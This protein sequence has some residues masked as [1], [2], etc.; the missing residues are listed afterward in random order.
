MNEEK[1][2]VVTSMLIAVGSASNKYLELILLLNAVTYQY[3]INVY[4]YH[5]NFHELIM[6]SNFIRKLT[7]VFC[8][9]SRP[10]KVNNG[11]ARFSSVISTYT[12]II[13]KQ[14]MM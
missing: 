12:N 9:S 10:Y 5:N 11:F 14:K 6:E 7:V 4:K 3:E 8:D 1:L 2:L 13:C